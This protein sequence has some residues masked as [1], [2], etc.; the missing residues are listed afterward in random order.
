MLE[1]LMGGDFEA[2]LQNQHVLDLLSGDGSG[3]GE[4]IEAYLEG[5]VSRYL[6]CGAGDDQA[7]R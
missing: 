1:S 3:A 7:D 5:R 6:T 4:D 2:V